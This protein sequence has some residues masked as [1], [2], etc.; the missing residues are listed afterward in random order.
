[1]ED[2]KDRALEFIQTESTWLE[3]EVEYLQA[4]V[5]EE[6]LQNL[7]KQLKNLRQKETEKEK[8]SKKKDNSQKSKDK[9]GEKKKS[10]K[11][12]KKEKSEL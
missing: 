1:M 7:K 12:G 3:E 8:K 2:D 11:K 5:Y 6:H 9:K 4:S 10:N